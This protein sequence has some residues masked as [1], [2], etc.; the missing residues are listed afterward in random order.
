MFMAV[1]MAFAQKSITGTVLD[2]ETGEPLIGVA[3]RVPGTTVGVLSDANGKF[4]VT[5]PQGQ[6]NLSFSFAGMKP[7]TIAAKPGMVVRLETDT[8]V[9]DD[10]M[11]IAYGTQKKSAFTGSAAVVSSEELGKIQAT[12]AV[13]AIKGKASGVQIYN[14]TGQPGSVPSIRIRG[15]N[16]I[17]GSQSPLIVLDGSPYDGSMNDINPTDIESMTVLK[18]AASTALYGARGG[19]GVILITTK[20]AKKGKDAAITVDAKWGNN[21][22]GSADYS[23]IT[24]PAGY[25]ETYYKGLYNYATNPN[26][27]GLGAGKGMNATNAWKW[28]NDNLISRAGGYGLGYNVY[29]VPTG[30]AMIGQNGKLNPN[31]TLGNYVTGVDGETYYLYPERYDDEIYNNSLRQE[32]TVSATGATDKGTFYASA[33]Y[34]NMDGITYGSDYERFTGRLKA[35]YQLKK[36]ARLGGNMSYSHFNRNYLSNEGSSNSGNLFALHNMA[37]IYPIY[38]RDANGK[39]IFSEK[40]GINGYDYGDGSVLGFTRP[41]LSQSNPLSDNQLDTQENEGNTFNGTGTLDIFLPYGFTFT[42][43]NNVYLHE[44][45]YTSVTNPYFGQYAS[46]NGMVT[47]EHERSWSTNYQQRLD[48]HKT[49]GKHDI[50]VMAGHEYYRMYGYDLYY[51]MNNM[52]S[53]SNK[54]LAGAVV[55]GSGSS[56]KS[57]YNTESWLT[58]AMYNYD[59]RIYAQASFMRQGSSTF[60][61]DHC[62][63]SF[64]SASAGWMMSKEKWFNVSWIDELKLKASYGENGNDGISSYLYTNRYSIVNSNDAVSLVPS[65]IRENEEVTWEKN[66]KFNVGVD[67][68]L[69]K[70]RIYGTVEYYRNVTNDLLSSVPFAPSFGYTS[71][72]ANVGNMLNT[73]VELDLHADV[74]RTKDFTWNVWA[75]VTSNHNEIT[76]LAE[77]RKT[78]EVDGY[79]GYSSGNYFYTEG[80][81]RYSYY[82]NE[83]AGIY[84]EDTYKKT[85]TSE[86]IADDNGPAYDPAKAGMAMYYKNEYAKVPEYDADGNVKKDADGKI[87]YTD[88]IAKDGNDSKIVNRKYAT[89]NY[90]EADMYILGDVLP[91][92]Y[93]GFGTNLTYKGFDLSVDFQYQ[94]GGKV[95]DSEYASL[96][97]LDAG[98]GFHTDLLNAWSS[99]NANSNIPRLNVSDSYTASTS[100][101]FLTSANYLS[102]SNITFGY[103]LPKSVLN[104]LNISKIRIYAVA[105]NVYTWTK[106]KGLDPRQSPTG[107]SSGIN[108][109]SIRSISGGVSVTF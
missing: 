50:E 39:I 75:N 70:N 17:L 64:W 96:M 1:G 89:V 91:D 10:I 103:T 79:H 38:Y 32:Y 35:D 42:S 28:A 18:D 40:A 52:F 65:T 59:E 53:Q 16:S 30:Q 41:Y 27:G 37:P 97:R 66:A 68:S 54:E 67:F 81:S 74:I 6:K 107:G 93:G 90:N 2:G 109:S 13:D 71:T 95:Y 76:K 102:L 9:M 83:Y 4:S 31:A 8:R 56:T 61:P 24:D 25:Y 62:W 86:Q 78:M 108:Y 49:Y 104:K 22:K 20:S 46:A 84:N 88:E 43:I 19:N 82:A 7:A 72:Y 69:F 21:M 45:R 26:N 99:E 87:I 94:L 15:Y 5:L 48:W 29:S 33:N 55:A 101:R 100:S 58:R 92:V 47:K 51:S 73:G 12:N 105:D 3:V 14:A 11:V 57:D 106:R 60:H 98:Y 85:W 44:N 63:G 34:L 80:L 77:E 23:R 36:W